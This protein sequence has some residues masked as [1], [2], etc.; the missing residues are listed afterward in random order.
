MAWNPE[1]YLRFEG[2]RF[3]PVL[4]LSSR[5][6]LAAPRRIVDLGCGTGSAAR[7][8][9]ARW[10][11][12]EITGVDA[13]PE[14][15][16]KARSATEAAERIDYVR[17]DIAGWAPPAPVDLV[18]TNAALQWLP[19]HYALLPRLLSLVAPGG[20][21]AVQMPRQHHAPAIALLG[22][23]VREGAW[24]ARLEPHLRIAPVHEPRVYYALLA[25]LARSLDMWETEYI[26]ALEG[27]NPVAEWTGGTWL[28]PLLAALEEP[29]RADFA[30][31]YRA[32]VAAAYPPE[33]D[34]RTLYPF[35]RLF[36]VA[37]K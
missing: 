34:G 22:E 17:S 20:V 7:L 4:D 25:P 6:S 37:G 8:M 29:E 26:Q 13:S 11:G 3:R 2:H 10:P 36:I 16:E 14:M 23:I 5:V 27:E 35:R 33:P 30:Q 9:R 1:I 19:D 24:R 18:F 12:A 21:L 31:R 28:P 15:L 32:R